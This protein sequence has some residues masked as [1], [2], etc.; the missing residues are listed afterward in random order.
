MHIADFVGKGK[1]KQTKLY[2]GMK[3]P[4]C[5]C[6]LKF[7]HPTTKVEKKKTEAH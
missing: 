7:V 1:N 3:C 6:R 5:L 2:F 4:H